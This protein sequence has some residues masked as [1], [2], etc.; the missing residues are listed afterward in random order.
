M[1][2]IVKYA[3]N[4]LNDY[5]DVISKV[6]REIL[7]P[8]ENFSKNIPSINGSYYTGYRY[9]ERSI[10]IEVNFVSPTKEEL[11]KKLRAF[12]DLLDVD[13]PKELSINDEPDIYY[14]AVPNGSFNVT[15]PS[16]LTA[17]VSIGFTCHNPVKFSKKWKSFTPA[18]KG[19]ITFEN[20]GTTDTECIIDVD[21]K[22]E[23]CFF[24][25]TNPKGETVLIGKPKDETKPVTPLTN[26]L[27][28]DNCESAS[29]FSA[30]ASSLL[31]SN[32]TSEGQYGVGHN[33]EGIVCTNYG[34]PSDGVW[35]GTAFKRS[36]GQ[37]VEEFEVVV[38][39]VFSSEGIN[40]T[41]PPPTPVT[42]PPTPSNPNPESVQSLGTWKVVNCG[43]L[44]INRTADTSQ[45]LYAMS[46]G[47]LIY[48]T[49][50]NGIW[51][52]HT[53][54]N[55]WNTFTGWSS[56]KYLQKVSDN[57]K[58]VLS[59]RTA[60]YAEEEIGLLEIYGY[61]QNGAK[62]FKAEVS[63]TNK[64]YE[65]VEPRV[66]F[67][68]KLVVD[69]GKNCPSP[70]KITVG[71]GDSKEQREVESGVFGDWNDL[72][73]KV[74]IRRE[75]NSKG[76][77]MWSASVYRYKN[78]AIQRTMSTSNNITNSALPTGALNYLG[79]YIGK[80]G[81]NRQV[82]VAVIKNISVKRLNMKTDTVSSSNESLF[83]NKDHLQ[84]NFKSGLVTLNDVEILTNVDIGSEFFKIPSGRSQIVVRTDDSSASIVAGIQ[85]RFL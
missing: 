37:N 36:I 64:Y 46:P 42:P 27:V 68:N 76:Q 6:D 71:E 61:D 62:L 5:C 65:Y 30:L 3:G 2:Y 23:A 38:D 85:E 4:T 83:K 26:I 44:Y 47:T 40:Y 12:A 56:S 67:G 28:D 39:F 73:G 70:R 80:L 21:F 15:K 77:Y 50:K 31:D 29:A 52:K 72:D 7:P 79:F 54:S 13:A 19:I 11:E 57:R 33:G 25:V 84:I 41:V 78:G 49:E 74:V 51:M 48:P 53:H 75:R 69:D 82:D 66:Y 34:S 35:G 16:K 20:D 32:R 59:A 8:R 18:S 81:S 43:G 22:K 17:T 60:E 14:L 58:S 63:D 55:A 10:T 1:K 45:P 9:G 24:Q